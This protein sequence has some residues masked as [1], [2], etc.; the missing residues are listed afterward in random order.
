MEQPA[1][2]EDVQRIVEDVVDDATNRLD[3]TNKER[4]QSVLDSVFKKAKSLPAEDY[5]GTPFHYQSKNAG[6]YF[7]PQ[8]KITSDVAISQYRNN[9]SSSSSSLSGPSTPR[10]TYQVPSQP[11]KSM[12]P[13]SEIN[14]REHH[15]YENNNEEPKQ[16]LIYST[17]LQDR[18]E[19]SKAHLCEDYKFPQ[20]IIPCPK[21]D[22]AK[23]FDIIYNI[24][25]VSIMSEES[26]SPIGTRVVALDNKIQSMLF[27]EVSGDIVEA[28]PRLPWKPWV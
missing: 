1:T 27:F 14:D 22:D 9:T 24:L 12:V 17:L 18:L 20:V 2:R 4:H 8:R 15:E 13:S 6:I 16:V 5:T 21:F 28:P 10:F 23:K 11:N 19:P 7:T 3:A 25:R 26:V